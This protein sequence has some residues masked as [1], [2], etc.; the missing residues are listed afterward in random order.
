MKSEGKTIFINS[1]LL[2]EVELICDRVAILVNG[3]VRRVGPVEEITTERTQSAVEFTVRA[4]EEAV[5]DCF[6]RDQIQSW[7]IED[8]DVFR[9]LVTVSGQGDVNRGI[10]ELRKNEV[11]IVSVTRPRDSLEEAFMTIVTNDKLE[12]E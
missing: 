4:S 2:Q 8:T 9:L 1:H 7:V 12:T 6:E 3:T 5:R 11:D 10:D